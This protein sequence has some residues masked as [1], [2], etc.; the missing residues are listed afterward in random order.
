M[1]TFREAWQRVYDTLRPPRVE[2]LSDTYYMH[3]VNGKRVKPRKIKIKS[4][5]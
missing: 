5:R 2:P 3:D 4:R 1:N